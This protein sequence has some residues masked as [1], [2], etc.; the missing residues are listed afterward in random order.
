MTLRPAQ[1]LLLNSLAYADVKAFAEGMTTPRDGRAA[2]YCQTHVAVAMLYVAEEMLAGK[3]Q[4]QREPI[5]ELAFQMA[6][7]IASPEK[8]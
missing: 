3:P 7:Q 8:Q 4:L 1:S 6:E 2:Q 5:A